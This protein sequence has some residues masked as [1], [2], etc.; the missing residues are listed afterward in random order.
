M[1]ESLIVTDDQEVRE[2]IN[3]V[4]HSLGFTVTETSSVR[5]AMKILAERPEIALVVTDRVFTQKEGE[6]L[7]YSMQKEP[8]LSSIPVIGLG[9]YSG[10]KN[11]YK[12]LAVGAAAFV[13]KP[14]F[15]RYFKDYVCRYASK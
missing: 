9:E 3:S 2:K 1:R 6:W 12:L 4:L 7:I 10:I 11:I 14:F 13:P 8:S 5:E 15:D